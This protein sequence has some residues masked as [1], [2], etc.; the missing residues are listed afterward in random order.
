M[1]TKF[2][3][4]LLAIAWTAGIADPRREGQYVA[5][6][7]P[8]SGILATSGD[9][10]TTF[11]ADFSTHHIFDPGTLRSPT[12]MASVSVLAQSGA[13]ADALATAMM[14]M[15]AEKSLELARNLADVEVLLVSKQ[16]EVTRTAGFPVA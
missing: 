3:F 16:G 6:A 12:Q 11:S 1:K 5:L 2:L 4:M 10:A 13:H 8:L 15:P 9:Y 14:V 7:Q